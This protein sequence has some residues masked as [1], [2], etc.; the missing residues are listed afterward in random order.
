[1]DHY[2]L[3]T[4]GKLHHKELVQAGLQEQFVRRHSPVAHLSNR[5]RRSLRLISS[6]IVVLYWLL[7]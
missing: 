3:E 6:L 1:M 2:S 7:T 5:F 4:L